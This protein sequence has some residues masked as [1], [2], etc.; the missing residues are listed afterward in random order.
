MWFD[1]SPGNNFKLN[2]G[3]LLQSAAV[4]TV[5]DAVSLMTHGAAGDFGIA[6]PQ[7]GP[8]GVECRIGGPTNDFK[9]KVTFDF[10]VAVTGSPQAEVISGMGI[11]GSGGVSN[12]GMVTVMGNMVTIPLT[13]VD[14]QQ[15]I[16]V[17]L[18]GVTTAVDR[19]ATPAVDVTIPMS[20]LLGDSTGNRLVNGGDIAQ[21]KSRTGQAVTT[22]NFRSDLNANGS[23]N[24]G[25]I[26][27]AKANTGHGVP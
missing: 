16:M 15:T 17:R 11:V 2:I 22:A 24:A 25:D 4:P 26:G 6:L 5:T 8:T 3:V 13:N 23:I 21:V 20:R 9:I 27:I 7:T 12:G 14:D 10:N 1:F 19:P 18:N